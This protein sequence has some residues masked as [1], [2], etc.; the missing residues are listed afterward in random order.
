MTKLFYSYIVVGRMP[1]V[2]DTYVPTH[3]I[4]AVISNQKDIIEL[5]RLD[6][7]KYAKG[8][9][10]IKIQ[11][12]LGFDNDFADLNKMITTFLFH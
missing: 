12:I 8:N 1:Q 4:G 3:D 5:Y 7:A 10:R 11:A 9:D 6:I 2:A